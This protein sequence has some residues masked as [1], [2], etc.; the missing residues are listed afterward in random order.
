[1]TT[2]NGQLP[3]A[4]PVHVYDADVLRR[5]ARLET[6]VA[7]VESSR[8]LNGLA[9][10]VVTVENR[11]RQQERLRDGLY[12]SMYE[13]SCALMRMQRDLDMAVRDVQELFR[14]VQGLEPKP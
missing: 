4:P 10:E 2:G 12:E 7:R 3:P 6:A 14:R 5:L 11:I 13:M 1:M 9:A 8:D